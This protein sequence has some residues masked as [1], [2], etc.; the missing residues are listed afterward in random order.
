MDL[1]QIDTDE[2]TG[3]KV[4]NNLAAA[5]NSGVS[6]RSVKDAINTIA[7]KICKT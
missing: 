4:L 5:V 7:K 2:K 6:K 1:L 3:P